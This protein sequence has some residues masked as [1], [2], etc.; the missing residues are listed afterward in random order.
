MYRVFFLVDLGNLSHGEPRWVL[1]D[2]KVQNCFIWSSK[3]FLSGA[4]YHVIMEMEP[5]FDVEKICAVI[6]SHIPDATL[7]KH[8]RAELS[9]NL[10][11]EY[12]H[13]Y[14]FKEF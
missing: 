1:P 5:Q 2:E 13:R 10:P 4:T 3:W 6:Q 14:R 7:E 12:V 8:T 11:K 9:F